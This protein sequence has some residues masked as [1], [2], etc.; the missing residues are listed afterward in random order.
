MYPRSRS[1]VLFTP[2]TH[3]SNPT[4]RRSRNP[5]GA[6]AVPPGAERDGRS[7]VP[8]RIGR[9]RRLDS[10]VDRVTR[11][12]T[13][14]Y[15]GAVVTFT[16]RVRTREDHADDPAT[17]HLAF[18]TD[19]S[20][21]DECQAHDRPPAR[22]RGRRPTVATFDVTLA[23]TSLDRVRRSVNIRSVF[24]QSAAQG[25][26]RAVLKTV[27]YRVLMVAVTVLVAFLVTGRVDQ[28]L[29]VGFWA[30][31]A[32]TGIYYGYERLWD[33]VAWGLTDA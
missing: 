12:P 13:A 28:A 1:S 17:E 27:L 10:L 29:H 26:S 9:A 15:A 6:I 4:R 16:G 11:C 19:D 21:A 24:R 32:K 8:G 30:N 31:L 3:T 7:P 2:R 33:H 22:G 14:E 25:R 5:G 20:V 18:E 23:V